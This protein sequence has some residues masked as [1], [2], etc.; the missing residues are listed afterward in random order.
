MLKPESKVVIATTNPGKMREFSALLADCRL[1]AIPQ[2]EFACDSPEETG[3]SFV[4]NAIIKARHAAR[5]TGLPSLADDSG[6]EV[7][8]LNGAPGIYSARYAGAGA[9]DRQNNQ[10][11]LQELEGFPLATR[12]ARYHCLIVLMHHAEDPTPVIC[13]GSWEGYIHFQP[14][15]DGGF[16]YDPVFWLPEKTC[17]AAQLPISEKNRISH[18]AQAMQNLKVKLQ[19]ETG[20]PISR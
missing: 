12:T 20:A 7:D 4:E 3:L 15:G 6:I 11:L 5:Q 8:A 18:R 10:K 13:Q 1:T 17:T 2:T 16:G 14:R 19:F 9:N